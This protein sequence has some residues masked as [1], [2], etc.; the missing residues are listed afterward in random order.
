MNKI[1]FFLKFFFMLKSIEFVLPQVLNN[2][3]RLGDDQFRYSHFNF[4]SNGDMIID[5]EA[6]PVLNE[7]R[8]FGLK[9]NGQ[10]YFTS[11]NQLTPYLSLHAENNSRRI[12][13]ESKFIK[14]KSSNNK[15]NGRELLCGISKNTG[16]YVEFYNLKYKNTPKYETNKMFG[17][18]YSNIFSF[19]ELPDN[20]TA[21]YTYIITYLLKNN[22]STYLIIRKMKFTFDN[23][24]GY[25]LIKETSFKSG[26]R[27]IVSCFLQ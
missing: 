19:L 6:Y 10:F 12:E 3:I 20:S 4:N 22:T 2:I 7:R 17:N 18:I 24:N 8:F 13:G 27:R 9:K 23:S 16:Y 14:L 26:E 11:N 5:T 1:F 21:N 15:F 25:E